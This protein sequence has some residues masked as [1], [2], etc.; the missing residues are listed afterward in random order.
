MIVKSEKGEDDVNILYVRRDVE[1][2]DELVG[3]SLKRDQIHFII[4]SDT[5]VVDCDSGKYLLKF[6]KKILNRDK[7]DTFY[8]NVIQHAMKKTGLR[9]NANSGK[10]FALTVKNQPQQIC[11]IR[12]NIFG[13]Y[14][15]FSP[16]Q[17]I[18]LR[19]FNF[20]PMMKV[21]E[22]AFNMLHQDKFLQTLPLL[23]EIDSLYSQL[24]PNEYKLQKIESLKTPFHIQDTCFTTVTTNVNFTTTCHKDKNDFEEGFGNLVVIEHDQYTGG[25]TCFPEYSLGVDVRTGDVLFMDVHKVHG[26]LPINLLNKDSVRLS[27]VCYLRKRITSHAYGFTTKQCLTHLKQMQKFFITK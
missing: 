7:I 27:I 21:R 14:E 22:C 18:K 13:Y 4:T 2:V 23:K 15:K 19:Q 11:K 17:S 24:M 20:K 9:S 8:Q 6:R 26:N 5:D 3:E 25:E 12:S 16:D 1:K 10:T